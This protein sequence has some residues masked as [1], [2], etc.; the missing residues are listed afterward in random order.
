MGAVYTINTHWIGY[1]KKISNFYISSFYALNSWGSGRYFLPIKLYIWSIKEYFIEI[2]L[3]PIQLNVMV[4]GRKVDWW[5]IY[6]FYNQRIQ[7]RNVIIKSTMNCLLKTTFSSFSFRSDI[8][9]KY[10]CVY[11]MKM[12][13][14]FLSLVFV[15]VSFFFSDLNLKANVLWRNRIQKFCHGAIQSSDVEWGTRCLTEVVQKLQKLKNPDFFMRFD[16]SSTAF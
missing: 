9:Y 12:F 3:T 8:Y 13:V 14:L 15:S 1:N 6:L 7:I 16:S 11:T 4:K 10:A 2:S 5:S